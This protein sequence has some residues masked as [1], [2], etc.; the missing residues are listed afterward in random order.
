MSDRI[1]STL[2]II[3]KLSCKRH[4]LELIKCGIHLLSWI[5]S[6]KHYASRCWSVVTTWGTWIWMK[7]ITLCPSW[8]R[9]KRRP[10]WRPWSATAPRTSCGS[11]TT[12]FTV[13]TFSSVVGLGKFLWNHGCE[14]VS[15]LQACS[16]LAFSLSC[17]SSRFYSGPHISA[18]SQILYHSMLKRCT[19]HQCDFLVELAYSF[20]ASYCSCTHDWSL[21]LLV[22]A[23]ACSLL[24]LHAVSSQYLDFHN[25]SDSEQFVVYFNT[26]V[27]VI[28]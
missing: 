28:S 22:P 4:L 26:P 23:P 21:L 24:T 19:W 7:L 25:F 27:D 12:T 18:A 3:V 5:F 13:S 1:A 8:W 2:L 15:L 10:R 14:R 20:R 6:L 9:E 17:A 11:N 16:G